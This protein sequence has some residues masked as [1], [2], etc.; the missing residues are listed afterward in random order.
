MLIWLVFQFPIVNIMTPF[1][2]QVYSQRNL[3][4]MIASAEAS[5][6]ESSGS[7]PK[8]LVPGVCT[9]S[10][11]SAT[12]R[13]YI[14]ELEGPSFSYVPLFGP[15]TTVLIRNVLTA[16]AQAKANLRSSQIQQQQDSAE[17]TGGSWLVRLFHWFLNPAG[18]IGGEDNGE[19]IKK[20]LGHL[21]SAS[22][23]L[24]AF[25]DVRIDNFLIIDYIF[26]SGPF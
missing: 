26:N 24:A 4:H 15:E 8:S 2:L 16:A 13:Q 5:L 22:A 14:N 17:K 25:F 18:S 20:A 10:H 7:G 11:L 9:P 23:Q 1:S 19:E 12:V 21:E 6:T 3:K